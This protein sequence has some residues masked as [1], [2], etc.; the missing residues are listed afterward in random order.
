MVGHRAVK[1]YAAK[2]PVPRQMIAV[3]DAQSVVYDR[4][5]NPDVHSSGTTKECREGGGAWDE[6]CSLGY[7]TTV[8]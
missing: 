5:S 6:R 2:R 8:E 7:T 4:A 3:S 1:F